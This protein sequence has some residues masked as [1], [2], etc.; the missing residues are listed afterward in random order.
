MVLTTPAVNTSNCQEAAILTRIY[1]IFLA[2]AKTN[3]ITGN[4]LTDILVQW[5]VLDYHHDGK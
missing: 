5:M 4:M 3:N 2:L 1:L